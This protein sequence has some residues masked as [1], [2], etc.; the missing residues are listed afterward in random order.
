V[1]FSK[2]GYEEQISLKAMKTIVK[3]IASLMVI[4]SLAVACTPKTENSAA[5][6]TETASDS[7]ETVAPADEVPADSVATDSTAVH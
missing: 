4:A 7:V 3:S 2:S 1:T 5:T 6:E